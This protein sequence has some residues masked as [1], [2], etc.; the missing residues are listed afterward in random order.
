[1][2]RGGPARLSGK[3]GDLMLGGAACRVR[4]TCL[5]EVV[6]VLLEPAQPVIHRR[7][8]ELHALCELAQIELRVGS[9]PPSHVAQRGR[10]PIELA[11]G[12]Q[13]FYR[14][15]LAEA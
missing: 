1:M 7:F 4:P 14:S 6:R 11:G 3:G 13:P 15:R 12:F 10:H 2:R 5:D 9:S 8:G